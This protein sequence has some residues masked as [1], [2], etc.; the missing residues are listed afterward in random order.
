[1]AHK[2]ETVTCDFI[3]DFNVGDNMLLTAN[4]LCGLKEA[5]EKGYVQ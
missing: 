1:M 3:G 4:A 5:N 2:V